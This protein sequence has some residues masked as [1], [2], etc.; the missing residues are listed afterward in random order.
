MAYDIGSQI[1]ELRRRR[2]LTLREVSRQTGLSTG[3][4]SQLERGLTDIALDSLRKLAAA[5]EAD[6]AQFLSAPRLGQRRTLRSYER[7]LAQ[8]EPGRFIH[9]HLTNQAE[10]KAMLP[11][12]VELLPINSDEAIRPYSHE[13]EEFLY[14]LEGI[15]T[16]HL[17]GEQ[18]E[19]CPGDS[20]HYPSALPH[21]WANYTN[22]VVRLLVVSHPNP[23]GAPRA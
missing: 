5:L 18:Q 16:L 13:G 10:P 17:A 2:G 11:R 9:Y 6:P 3:F 4:L 1:K 7:S 12:L 20:A 22:K 15:L 21:N 19:L 23:H 8:V 14:V